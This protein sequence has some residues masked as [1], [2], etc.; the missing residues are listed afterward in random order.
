MFVLPAAGVGLG[1]LIGHSLGHSAS[2]STTGTTCNP[3]T[4]GCN[5]QSTTVPD[6]Q[7]RDMAIG[8]GVGLAVGGIAAF[9]LV[10]HSHNFYL[11][12]GSPVQMVLQ[13]PLTI[14]VDQ[15]ADV[16]AGTDSP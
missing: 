10:T 8:G 11:D 6:T 2:F 13:Q 7:V 4:L 16:P 1:T 3:F 5:P 9:F 15:V 12:Q 14:D